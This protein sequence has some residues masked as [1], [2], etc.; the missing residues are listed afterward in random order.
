MK[1]KFILTLLF[2]AFSA[3]FLSSCRVLVE[4]EIS[5]NGSGTL[6]S[7]VVFSAQEKANFEASPENAGKSLCD[8]LKQ[9]VEADA[10]FVQEL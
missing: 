8:S 1:P 5:Q 3:L 9:G 6:R 4:T 2:L 7:S 10:E